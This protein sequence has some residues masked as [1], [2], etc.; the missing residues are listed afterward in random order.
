MSEKV[1][2]IGA[3]V[4]AKRLGFGKLG[5]SIQDE[6]YRLICARLER[7][8]KKEKNKKFGWTDIRPIAKNSTIFSDNIYTAVFNGKAVKIDI[9]YREIR[10][11]GAPGACRAMERSIYRWLDATYKKNVLR[12]IHKRLGVADRQALNKWRK[13]QRK[14]AKATSQATKT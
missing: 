5:S 4:I 3:R 9:V 13:S 12:D 2:S 1:A 7:Q 10:L 6:I 8:L 11:K 14:I